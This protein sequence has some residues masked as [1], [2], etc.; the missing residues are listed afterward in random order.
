MIRAVVVAAVVVAVSA[1]VRAE[2][3][4]E[5][6]WSVAVGIGR[7]STS[8]TSRADRGGAF[9]V[10]V[11]L[12][13]RGRWGARVQYDR[14]AIDGGTSAFHSDRATHAL[15]ALGTGRLRLADQIYVAGGAGLAAVA[16]RTHHVTPDDDATST[17]FAAGLAWAAGVDVEGGR[18][19]VRAD[20]SGVWHEVAHD[21]V[22]GLS[23]GIRF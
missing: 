2:P 1:P 12:R 8:N 3:V 13:L 4:P 15:S 22:F 19:L 14:S 20:V 11:D 7:V 17:A 21:R 9:G 10:E 5:R 18:W 16:V 23:A 6:P